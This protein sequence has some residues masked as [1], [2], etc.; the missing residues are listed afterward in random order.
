MILI[1]L[2]CTANQCKRDDCHNRISFV[3]NSSKDVYIEIS[4]ISHHYSDLDTSKFYIMISNPYNYNPPDYFKVKSGEKGSVGIQRK[5]CLEG[6]V[7][8]GRVYVYVF[9]PEVLANFTWYVIGKEYM[10]L[11]TIHITTEEM[12][13]S[14]WT[15]TYTGE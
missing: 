13:M 9:D 4:G 2:I 6:W 3:N 1:W 8:K 7:A 12:E 14:N 11:K 5:N 10:V 15:I